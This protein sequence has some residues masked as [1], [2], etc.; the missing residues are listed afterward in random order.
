MT[1][2]MAINKTQTDGVGASMERKQKDSGGRTDSRCIYVC[3]KVVKQNKEE[4]MVHGFAWLVYLSSSA[5]VT[6]LLHYDEAGRGGGGVCS[7]LYA[8]EC[9][10]RGH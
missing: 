8:R 7:C 4:S 3:T 1:T 9:V 2:T 5:L 10:R 6:N